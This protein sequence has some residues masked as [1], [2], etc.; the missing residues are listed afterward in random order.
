MTFTYEPGD[1]PIV[2]GLPSPP[3]LAQVRLLLGDTDPFAVDLQDEEIDALLGLSGGSVVRAAYEGACRLEAKYS[4][5]TDESAAGIQTTRS[6]RH[7]QW[8]DVRRE[9]ERRLARTASPSFVG[10]SRS[11]RDAIWQDSDYLQ[12]EVQVGQGRAR[13]VARPSSTRAGNADWTD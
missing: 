2:D 3:A 13:N 7:T 12:P 11:E 8:R 6:Q 1:W 5:L 10:R 4:R 9:L